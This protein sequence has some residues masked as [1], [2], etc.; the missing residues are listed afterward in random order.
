[1]LVYHNLEKFKRK[2]RLD[3][4][5]IDC[6]KRDL[7]FAIIEGTYKMKQPKPFFSYLLKVYQAG[8]FPCGW[9]GEEP[10]QGKLLVL[11]SNGYTKKD[12]HTGLPLRFVISLGLVSHYLN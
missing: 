9:V 1:M 5:F 2:N 7:T 12:N 10:P 4:A 6:V 3:N 11:W 8:H